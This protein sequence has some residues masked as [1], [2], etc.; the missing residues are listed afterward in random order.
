M[1]LILTVAGSCGSHHSEADD[2]KRFPDTFSAPSRD[3]GS[4]VGR[5]KPVTFQKAPTEPDT[6]SAG[7][8]TLDTGKPK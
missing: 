2:Y 4:W 3:S 6:L 8:S 7:D 1:M 5:V